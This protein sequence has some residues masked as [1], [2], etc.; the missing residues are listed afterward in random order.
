M[1]PSSISL[2]I[3][4]KNRSRLCT[5]GAM[6]FFQRL[7]RWQKNKTDQTFPAFSKTGAF[8]E[9]RAGY[10]SIFIPFHLFSFRLMPKCRRSKLGVFFS[11]EKKHLE[12]RAIELYWGF[13]SFPASF[14]FSPSSELI[15]VAIYDPRRDRRAWTIREQGEGDAWPRDWTDSAPPLDLDPLVQVCREPQQRQEG[16]G[17]GGE[18][19]DSEV[20]DK[21]MA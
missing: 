8:R 18:E 13:R 2:L 16:G 3:G 19:E 21:K 1:C 15:L 5:F 10:I 17:R 6:S 14:S 7:T 20:D 4:L 12:L 11:K 9:Q